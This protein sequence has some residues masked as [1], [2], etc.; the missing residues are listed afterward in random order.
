[1]PA[2]YKIL[3]G[4]FSIFILNACAINKKYQGMNKLILTGCNDY[5]KNI[6]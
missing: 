6:Y 1:M 4:F 3:I 2:S 5:L